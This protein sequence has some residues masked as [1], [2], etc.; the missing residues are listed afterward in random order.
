MGC[1]TCDELEYF[2]QDLLKCA[3]A[4]GCSQ[5]MGQDQVVCESIQIM[6]GHTDR[7]VNQE[8]FCPDTL[9]KMRKRVLN[10]SST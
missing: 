6:V 9:E 8:R 1:D 7:I 2:Q 3:T 5:I 10:T 4:T